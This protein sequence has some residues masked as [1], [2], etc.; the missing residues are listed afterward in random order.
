MT[1]SVTTAPTPLAMPEVKS[2]WQ[3]K[4][5]WLNVLSIAV[6]I[7]AITKPELLPISPEWLAWIMGVLNI[8]IRFLTNG[9]VSL[10]G[11]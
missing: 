2:I 4:T 3:S 1:S 10:T 6:A 11:R 8:L 7:L 9:P 5:F